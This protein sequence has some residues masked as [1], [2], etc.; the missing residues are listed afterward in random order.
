MRMRLTCVLLVLVCFAPSCKESAGKP[1]PEAAPDTVVVGEL[2]LFEHAGAL[3]HMDFVSG[4]LVTLELDR[5]TRWDVKTGGATVHLWGN[6]GG[7]VLAMDC[8]GEACFV[9]REHALMEV[10]WGVRGVQSSTL[11]YQPDEVLGSSITLSADESTLVVGSRERRTLRIY[12]RHRIF[13]PEEY[14]RYVGDMAAITSMNSASEKEGRSVYLAHSDGSLESLGYHKGFLSLQRAQFMAQMSPTVTCF[15]PSTAAG[16]VGWCDGS[17]VHLGRVLPGEKMKNLASTRVDGAP[18]ALELSGQNAAI[19]TK[20]GELTIWSHEDDVLSEERLEGL[21]EGKA[22]EPSLLKISPDGQSIAVGGGGRVWLGDAKNVGQWSSLH[23]TKYTPK[24]PVDSSQKSVSS[25]VHLEPPRVRLNFPFQVVGHQLNNGVLAVLGKEELVLWN[26]D[27]RGGLVRETLPKKGLGQCLACTLKRCFV[28]Q[29]QGVSTFARETLQFESLFEESLGERLCAV[30]DDGNYLAVSTSKPG[31]L[32]AVDTKTG[33][34]KRLRHPEQEFADNP[35]RAVAFLPDSSEFAALTVG[36]RQEIMTWVA[37]AFDMKRITPDRD[38]ICLA[39]ALGGNGSAWICGFDMLMRHSLDE[40][41][42]R[43]AWGIP[44]TPNNIAVGDHHL[45]ATTMQGHIAVYHMRGGSEL[46]SAD[47]IRIQDLI[48]LKG[49][50]SGMG[51]IPKLEGGSL[52]LVVDD[53]VLVG[54]AAKLSEW[55]AMKVRTVEVS[56]VQP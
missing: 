30:S 37:P 42:T 23:L 28:V 48:E 33:S 34:F 47:V 27:G 39:P 52:A 50:G 21:A 45:V 35:W 20:E 3:L 10:S 36:G 15:A 29:E 44:N 8:G 12:P 5:I 31:E 51:V 4:G 18:V 25:E 16:V 56:S 9:L 17:T 38:G 40:E 22:F 1:A 6:A 24:R 19:L 46:L 26:L 41:A 43:L 2:K 32:L 54:E 7:R 13:K 14:P 53:A 55:A 49:S 11:L